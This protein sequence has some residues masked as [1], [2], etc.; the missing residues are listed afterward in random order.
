MKNMKHILLAL[1]AVSAAATGCKSEDYDDGTTRLLRCADYNQIT[2]AVTWVGE[3]E[4]IV[5]LLKSV[6]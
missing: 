4:S 2:Q 3:R 1:L 5:L 6:N